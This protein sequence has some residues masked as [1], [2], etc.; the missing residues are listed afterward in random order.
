MKQPQV[1]DL[2]LYCGAEGN[3]TLDPFHAMEVLCQLSYS[4]VRDDRD[5]QRAGT[6][7]NV[8]RDGVSCDSI[9]GA[10]RLRSSLPP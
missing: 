10:V 1:C 2:G 8:I 4:P 9:A 7:P 5:Y 3:R 6:D